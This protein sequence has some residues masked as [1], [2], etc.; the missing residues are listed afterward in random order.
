M[1][2][3]A[4]LG[5]LLVVVDLRLFLVYTHV[6]GTEWEMKAH[7]MQQFNSQIY[8]STVKMKIQ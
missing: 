6:N 1:G 2:S 4:D 3:Q 5:V 7:Q 8:S